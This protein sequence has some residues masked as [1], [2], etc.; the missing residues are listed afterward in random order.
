MG[1]PSLAGRRFL[2]FGAVAVIVS[3]AALAVSVR[4]L[5][6]VPERSL[7]ALSSCGPLDS[8]EL[9]VRV[10]GQRSGEPRAEV[11]EFVDQTPEDI[12]PGKA[13]VFWTTW[14]VDQSSLHGYV[15]RALNYVEDVASP[16]GTFCLEVL[17]LIVAQEPGGEYS[18]VA[19]FSYDP[20]AVRPLEAPLPELLDVARGRGLLTSAQ[21][22][23]LADNQT[24]FERRFAEFLRAWELFRQSSRDPALKA[25]T[26]G[27]LAAMRP[28]AT[29]PV[30]S[31]LR[32][33]EF[34]S[35]DQRVALREAG[36]KVPGEIRQEFGQGAR[37]KIVVSDCPVIDLVQAWND[38]RTALA[39]D[40]RS[41]TPSQLEADPARANHEVSLQIRVEMADTPETTRDK[42]L[43]AL[44]SV[45]GILPAQ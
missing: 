4:V 43:S 38:G 3:A 5:W 39:L 33:R 2:V 15:Y 21:L 29:D 20:S 14:T 24:A 35:P 28:S 11:V 34:F 36:Y 30:A 25:R 27:A 1:W 44:L 40:A 17:P 6:H 7:S 41:L 8:R 31:D 10:V 42:V 19:R 37:Y 18:L 9:I 26:F 22:G 32:A 23:R 45:D 16:N 12:A 13:V